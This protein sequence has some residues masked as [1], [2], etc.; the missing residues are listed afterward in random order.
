MT[1]D[2]MIRW[3]HQL[4][5]RESEQTLGD[6]KGQ[7]SLECCSL[8]DHTVGH[9]LVTKQQWQSKLCQQSKQEHRAN[10]TISKTELFYI[11]R[12]REREKQR[13]NK[14]RYR[15]RITA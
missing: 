7:A 13:E 10:A 11:D 3:Y 8:Q 6:G 14:D 12:Y 5:G 4:N 2:E 1:E 9:N 15:F